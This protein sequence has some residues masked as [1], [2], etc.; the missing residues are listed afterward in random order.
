MENSISIGDLDN[1]DYNFRHQV[2]WPF[3]HVC[4]IWPRSHIVSQSNTFFLK[5]QDR[6]DRLD[7]NTESIVLPDL[8]EIFLKYRSLFVLKHFYVSRDCNVHIV[9]GAKYKSTIAR[10]EIIPYL[11]RVCSTGRYKP[12]GV[13]VKR[14]LE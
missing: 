7:I 11:G 1:L 5:P 10:P 3:G 12:L 9:H 14:N 4:A 6:L 2:A 8:K 13:V